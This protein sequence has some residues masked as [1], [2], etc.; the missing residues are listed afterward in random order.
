M[1]N[2]NDKKRIDSEVQKTLQSLDNLED[3]QA[4]PDFFAAIQDK[5]NASEEDDQSSILYRLL[6]KYRLAPAALALLIVL[7]VVSAFIFVSEQDYTASDRQ[8]SIESVADEYS[9][10][11]IVSLSDY[12]TE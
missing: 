11:G 1:N 8:I 3:L 5:I 2:S 12:D 9:I 4:G 10:S 7:N 6:F